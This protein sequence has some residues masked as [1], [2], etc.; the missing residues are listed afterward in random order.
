MGHEAP[1]SGKTGV[2]VAVERRR[3]TAGEVRLAVVRRGS[4]E[5]LTSF[6]RG[7]ID[8]RE[9][10]VFTDTWQGFTALT[11]QGVKHRPRLG[12]HGPGASDVLPRA[13][14]A[15]D[16]LKTWLQ[17]AFHGVSTRHLQRYLDE[18]VYRF[19][20]RWREDALSGFV[21]RRALRASP[22]PAPVSWLSQ[23]DR[24]S[25]SY[26]RPP[27]PPVAAGTNGRPLDRSKKPSGARHP[28]GSSRV[29]AE[30]SLV[31]GFVMVA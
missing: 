1:D 31:V 21:L 3:A 9:A 19:N 25:D 26:A 24:Q 27:P 15:F 13:H 29:E 7:A 22:S 17:G 28:W 16:N 14:T 10:T 18:F 30:F 5:E 20:R 23:S 12:G 11:S 4:S 2:A 8:A 6:V